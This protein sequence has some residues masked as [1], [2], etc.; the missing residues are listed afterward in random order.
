MK[1]EPS[2]ES[3]LKGSFILNTILISDPLMGVNDVELRK[4][5]RLLAMNP[6]VVY[7]FTKGLI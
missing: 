5:Y 3:A 1:Q 4:I 6:S 7:L 2:R